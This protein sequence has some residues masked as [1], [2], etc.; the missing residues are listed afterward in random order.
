[1][2]GVEPLLSLQNPPEGWP[3]SEGLRGDRLFATRLGGPAL[4]LNPHWA[5]DIVSDVL[6]SRGL[7]LE[8]GPPQGRIELAARRTREQIAK[9]LGARQ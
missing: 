4:A 5:Q 6:A 3:H 2:E 7:S 9:R 1:L 8:I